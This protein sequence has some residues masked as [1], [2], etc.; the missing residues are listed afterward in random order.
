MASASIQFTQGVT[1]VPAGRSALGF[2]NTT[3]V[4]MTDAGG[5]GASS[6]AW[7]IVSFPGP[8]G[9]APTVTDPNAQVASISGPFT[10]GI[11]IVKL[12]RTDGTGTTVDFKFFGVADADGLHLPSPGMTGSMANVGGA[13]TAQAAGWAGRADAATNTLLDAYLRWLKARSG[14]YEGKVTALAVSDATASP[15]TLSTDGGVGAYDVTFS[16]TSAHTVRLSGSMSGEKLEFVAYLQAGAS[17]LAFQNGVGS[18]LVTLSSPPVGAGTMP[19]HLRFVYD[20]TDWSLHAIEPLD[21]RAIRTSYEFQAVTGIQSASTDVFTRVGTVVVDP[22]KFPASVFTFEATLEVTDG[23]SVE[24]RLYN[25][26]DGG[27]VASSTLT[28]SAAAPTVLSAT[29]TLPSA[30]KLYEVQL[31]L[32]S[33]NGGTDRA[34]CTNAKILLTWS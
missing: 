12:V 26:T 22:S 33:A 15:Q 30:S 10:D 21:S 29:V 24:C 8:V 19:W 7:S 32:G 2:D 9:T 4:T 11:Y 31:R 13:A 5:A 23:Q 14:V 25:I 1:V 6:Y 28:S 16:K 20:G 27:V 17:T 3:T 34:S 18:T